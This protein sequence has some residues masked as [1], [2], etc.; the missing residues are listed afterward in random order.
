MDAGYSG[1]RYGIR[2]DSGDLAILSMY[3]W[4]VFILNKKLEKLKNYIKLLVKKLVK[5]PINL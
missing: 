2:L 3:L 5:I 4:F 1:E